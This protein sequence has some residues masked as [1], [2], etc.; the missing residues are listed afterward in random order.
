[1]VEEL[2]MLGDLFCEDCK[3]HVDHLCERLSKTI[4]IRSE[5]KQ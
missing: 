2:Q 1:M 4:Q 5:G 3:Q